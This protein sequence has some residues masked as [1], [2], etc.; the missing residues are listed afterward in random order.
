[1]DVLLAL[2]SSSLL[3][4]KWKEELLQVLLLLPLALELRAGTED[5]WR[6]LFDRVE[7]TVRNS[8]RRRASAITSFQFL[9][10]LA[11]AL[12]LGPKNNA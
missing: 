6:D 2:L 5:R 9:P 12:V 7:R 1:L 4:L 3:L 11:A 10:L 8:S